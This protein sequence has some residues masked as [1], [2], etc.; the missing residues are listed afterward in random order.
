[1]KSQMR[2]ADRL[3]ARYVLILGED[4]FA[5]DLVTIRSLAGGEQKQV[6]LPEVIDW[7]QENELGLNIRNQN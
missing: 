5:Q 2:E 7:L 1:M 4:E 6:P 3:S